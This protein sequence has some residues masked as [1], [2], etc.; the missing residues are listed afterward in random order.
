MKQNHIEA[1]TAYNAI[2]GAKKNYGKYHKSIFH[3]HTPESYDYTLKKAWSTNEYRSKNESDIIQLCIDE[4]IFPKEFSFFDFELNNELEIFSSLKE[5]FSF[6]LLGNALLENG[7]EIVVVS[8]HNSIGGI[9]KLEK[10]IKYLSDAKKYDVYTHIIAGVEISCADK[11]HVVCIFDAKKRMRVIEGWLREHLIND[12]EGTYETSKSVIEYFSSI[13]C[14][15]YI[16]HLNTADIFKDSKFLSGGYKKSLFTLNALHII[17]VKN[18]DHIERVTDFL[19]GYSSRN[20]NFILDNDSHNIEEISDRA[21]WIKGTKINYNMLVEALH[22][23]DVSVSLDNMFAERQYIKGIY[24]SSAEE[25]FLTNEDHKGAFVMRFSDALNCIIGGRGTGK[26][27]ILKMLEYIMAQRVESDKTLD[28]LCQHGNAYV[29]YE[30]E[31][32]EYI[33]EM[34][35]PIKENGGNILRW[36]GQ[37]ADDRYRYVYNF[38]EY[39]VQEYASRRYVSI[40][41]VK[42]QPNGISLEKQT[43]SKKLLKDFYDRYYSVNR[44]VQTASGS[45]INTFIFDLLF[46]NKELSQPS[47]AIRARTKSG[48]LR[49]VQSLNSIYEKRA[50]EVDNVIQSFNKS[51]DGKLRIKYSNDEI[52]DEPNFSEWVFGRKSNE[53]NYF[54][55]YN[56]NEDSLIGYIEHIYEEIGFEELVRLALDESCSKNRFDY[57]LIPFSEGFTMEMADKEIKEITTENE[58][59]VIN[60]IFSEL[61]TDE[62]ATHVIDYLKNTIHQREKF[63]L[64]FNLNSKESTE[65]VVAL[66]KDILELSLGQ[67]VVAMLDFILG[68]GEYINDYRPIIID[69]PEDNLDSRYIYQNLVEQLRKIKEKRQIIIATHNATIVTNAMSDLVCVMDSDGQHGW[70]KASGYPSESRIKKQIVVYL[71]GGVDSF[72]HKMHIYRD[73]IK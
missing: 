36:F 43:N 27:S 64:E 62:N 7:I 48:I 22:D 38:S 31:G 70:I 65:N 16:A 34:I 1:K 19:K 8:D 20:Y 63:T 72:K 9:K 30:K 14:L 24:I 29:L 58:K 2:C 12:K 45:E 59:E 32:I 41:K 18:R 4:N 5:F 71:E 55:G 60:L 33:I 23:F 6:V 46:E 42:N 54:K 53:R 56:I 37:N 21:F 69:Q 66:Y 49:T 28:F 3:L 73:V 50:R 51:Q 61:I 25:G 47:D 26:S 39:D 10:T 44:L 17:G 11:L 67:K 68:Y 13:G 57:P 35:L 52:I 40:F 15:A